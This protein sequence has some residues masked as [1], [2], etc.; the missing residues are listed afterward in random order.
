MGVSQV[1]PS[2]RAWPVRANERRDYPCVEY[3]RE[4]ALDEFFTNLDV[5]LRAAL[6]E[7]VAS[8]SRTH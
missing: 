8:D 1:G 3:V 4:G 2:Y 5:A 7:H 6:G